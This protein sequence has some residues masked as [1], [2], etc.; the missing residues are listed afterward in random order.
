[1]S[2]LAV[3]ELSVDFRQFSLQQ[4]T[5]GLEK[6]QTLV[7]LGPSGAGKSVLLETIAGFHRVTGGRILLDGLDVTALPPEQRGL[8][9]MFQD[10]ALFPHLT[11]EQNVAFGIRGR[12]D[13]R[14][15]VIEALELVG[16]GH[17]LGRRPTALSGGEKQ[18]VALARALAIE[19]R[20]FLFDEPLSALDASTREQLRE[21]LRS[22]LRSLGATALYVTHDRL[23]ALMLAD[24]VAVIEGGR[25][26]QLGT[27]GDVF[28]HPVDAWVARFL[29]M[30]L[31][32]P[33]QVRPDGPGTAAVLWG[34]SVL[35]ASS[36][37][38]V[39]A[40]EQ[41]LAFRPEDVHL[42]RGGGQ[43]APPEGAI[44]AVVKGVVPLGPMIRV[45]LAGHEPF[46]ALLPRREQEILHL[47]PGDAL[48]AT[49]D[50]RD[51]L[52]VP[53]RGSAAAVRQ[54]A[55]PA[56]ELNGLSQRDMIHPGIHSMG[57]EAHPGR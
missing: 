25:I 57:D 5:L 36:Q 1:M 20:L 2:Y 54:A 23:E 6:G 34:G 53:E 22:L 7:I 55:A 21:E 39:A 44:P 56:H 40:G 31:L 30:Q 16:A 50:P 37:Y 10:Y 35:R 32:R 49:L 38:G 24:V 19:P 11:V 28:D 4:I 12:S 42:R 18:R 29:G 47:A 26:R 9:F 46:S 8:G 48:L 3:R 45:D 43:T 41:W 27:P 15:R 13:A 33:E 17:L 52:L 51:L 14:D